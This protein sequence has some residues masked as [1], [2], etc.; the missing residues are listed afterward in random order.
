MSK[1]LLATG[2]AL[3]SIFF[4]VAPTRAG[5][6]NPAEPG[7]DA[8]TPK[9]VEFEKSLF[10]LRTVAADKVER[11]NPLRMRYVLMADT[12]PESFPRNW[13]AAQRLSIEAYLIRRRKL[14]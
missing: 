7:E 5:I 4:I 9:F 13:S 8:R 10:L 11:D 3:S 2:A 1:R 14:G 6:Y 12:A